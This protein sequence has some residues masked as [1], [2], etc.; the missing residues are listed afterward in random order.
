[1]IPGTVINRRPTVRV[2]LSNV[3]GQSLQIETIVDTGFTGFFTLAIAAVS[4]LALPFLNYFDARLA[5]GSH[6]RLEVYAATR[7]A[8]HR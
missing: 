5:D 6:V 2:V 7:G 4:A 3:Q 1:M 8:T